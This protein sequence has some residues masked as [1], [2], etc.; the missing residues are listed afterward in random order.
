MKREGPIESFDELLSKANAIEV[1]CDLQR[2]GLRGHSPLRSVAVYIARLARYSNVRL[3][4]RAINI[5]S[6]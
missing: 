4:L 5:L 6:N 3:P 1:M 2:C